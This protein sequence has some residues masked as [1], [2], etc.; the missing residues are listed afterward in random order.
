MGVR[1]AG[2]KLVWPE[3]GRG[4]R[5]ECGEVLGPLSVHRARAAWKAHKATLNGHVE[6]RI[7][8]ALKELGVPGDGYPA[9]VANAVAILSDGREVP[10]E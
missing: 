6:D 8:R 4:W 9:P 1:T 3:A 7:D 10:S 2:H 5:C